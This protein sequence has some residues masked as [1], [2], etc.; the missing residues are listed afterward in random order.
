MLTKLRKAYAEAKSPTI[1]SETLSQTLARVEDAISQQPARIA[2][3]IR[4]ELQTSALLSAGLQARYL[5]SA[6]EPATPP[7]NYAPARPQSL[8]ASLRRM[9]AL[10]PSLFPT[11]HTL[12]EN[13]ARSYVEQREASCSHWGQHYA[14]LFGAF[15]SIHAYGRLL[16]VGCG[17]YGLPSYLA[18]YPLEFISGLEPLPLMRPAPFECAV[19]FNEFLPWPDGAFH[20]VVSGTSLDHV[21]SLERSLEEVRRVLVPRGRFLVWLASIPGAKAFDPAN[22]VAIDQYHLFHFDRVWIEPLLE[23]Y[24]TITDCVIVPQ[25]GF[26]H[27]FYRLEPS[28]GVAAVTTE[29]GN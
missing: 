5:R 3:A 28:A 17:Q 19:G 24:F 13:G 16:D 22:P 21:I 9:E 6:I 1:V 20:T 26:D 15:V 4:G 12:F 25:P 10:A 7:S 2:E 29:G 18:G 11:W 27:M 8:Q 23:R 14:R